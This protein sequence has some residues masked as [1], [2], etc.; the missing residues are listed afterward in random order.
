MQ[1]QVKIEGAAQFE[2]EIKKLLPDKQG[3]ELLKKANEDVA[4][5]IVKKAIATASTPMEKKASRT[6][7]AAKSS[8]GVYVLGGSRDIPYFGGANFG[9]NHDLLRLIKAR[10][11]RGANKGRRSRATTI[12]KEEEWKLDKIVRKIESQYVS[13]SGKTIS[14]YEAGKDAKKYQ[15]KLQR[16]KSGAIRSIRGWNQFKP[17]TKGKDYFLYASI[18]SNFDAIVDFYSER[19]AQVSKDAFPD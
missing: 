2:R 12:R 16:T 13:R 5:F 14:K 3:V 19:M 4:D 17:W 9:A 11:V 15:V 6:M 1:A 8:A 7:T 18:K 10:K